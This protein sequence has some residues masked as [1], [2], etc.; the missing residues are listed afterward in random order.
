MLNNK[1]NPTITIEDE[2][3]PILKLRNKQPRIEGNFSSP[4]YLERR[5]KQFNSMVSRQ[6]PESVPI[7]VTPE[8][9]IKRVGPEK[10]PIPEDR[11]SDFPWSQFQQLTRNNHEDPFLPSRYIPPSPS[12]SMVSIPSD[13]TGDFPSD[14]TGDSPN[15]PWSQFQQLT[16]NDHEDPFLPS[17]YIPPSPSLSPRAVLSKHPFK[18]W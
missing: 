3:L 16:R 8:R 13:N 18:M 17:R 2:P 4:T 14:N 15:S 10:V 7:P 11:I 5:N 6:T 1:G 9:K 12:P